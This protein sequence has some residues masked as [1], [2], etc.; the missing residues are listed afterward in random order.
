MEFD[1][2]ILAVVQT[3]CEVLRDPHLTAEGFI[4]VAE[5]CASLLQKLANAQKFIL[6][7]DTMMGELLADL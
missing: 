1:C 2:D 5:A 7:L 4:Q 3:S 6:A